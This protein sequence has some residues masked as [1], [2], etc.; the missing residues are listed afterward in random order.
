MRSLWR[1]PIVA[2]TVVAS[3]ALSM[4]PLVAGSRGDLELRTDRQRYRLGRNVTIRLV[5]DGS[6]RVTFSSPWVI[7]HKESRA[8]VAR[9][10]FM[11]EEDLELDAGEEETWVWDQRE[12]DCSIDCPMD[13]DE[14]TFVAPARYVAVVRT[15]EGKLRRKFDIGEYFTLGFDYDEDLSFTLY[16][17]RAKAVSEMYEDAEEPDPE[18]K[19]FIVSGIVRD[20][21]PYNPEWSYSMSPGSTVL[22]EAFIEVC[23]ADPNY[24]EENLDAWMGERWCPWGG[25]V[26]RVGR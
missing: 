19:R 7:K 25:Y 1:R 13:P 2:L 10:F 26:D 11:F 5:N 4:T 24:V 3:L 8:V 9:F 6:E 17:R 14:P 20:A 15:S 21:V 22:G 12:G 23:D 16:S 18:K